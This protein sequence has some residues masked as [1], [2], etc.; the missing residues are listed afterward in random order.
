MRR[1]LLSFFSMALIAAAQGQFLSVAPPQKVVVK[2]G[3]TAE[4][5]LDVTLQSGYHV[6][7][8]M[9]SEE[10]LIPLRLRWEPG[11]LA[12][13]DVQYPKP[14]LENYS[15]SQKPVSVFTDKFQIVTKLSAQPSAPPGP[16]IMTAKLRYQ[17]C[18]DDRCFPPRTLEVKIP[19]TIQ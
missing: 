9:P 1:I 12:A 8:N 5:R 14:K 18:T 4:A 7:S 3:G 16:G 6:N 13:V 2:R 10:Y 17:A 11:P 19:Y 15:F